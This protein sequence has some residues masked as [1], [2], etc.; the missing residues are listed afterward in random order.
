MMLTKSQQFEFTNKTE[1]LFYCVIFRLK[2]IFRARLTIF[3]LWEKDEIESFLKIKGEEE[4]ENISW[5]V[6]SLWLDE[7]L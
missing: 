6:V 5:C 7:A 4:N 1:M 2:A 3:F